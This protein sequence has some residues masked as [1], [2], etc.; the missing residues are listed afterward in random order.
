MPWMTC[1]LNVRATIEEPSTTHGTHGNGS[2]CMLKWRTVGTT[3]GLGFID[4]PPWAST[5][6]RYCMVWWNRE[7]SRLSAG[8]SESDAA[9]PR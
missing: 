7:R 6:T 4:M 8:H 2:L 3:I 9:A 1:D 5:K